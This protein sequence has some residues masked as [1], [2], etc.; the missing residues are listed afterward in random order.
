M[1]IPGNE[2]A[3]NAARSMSDLMQQ[4]F[5]YQNLKTF[6]L[7]Y[8]HRVWQ[9]TWDQQVI[10]KLHRIHLSI[11]HWAAVPVRRTHVHF[12]RTSYRAHLYNAEIF[13]ARRES[14]NK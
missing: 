11:T 8:I 5:C 14:P 12:T 1:S 4:P 2:L 9:K 10:N 7:C 13:V 3:D 6:M